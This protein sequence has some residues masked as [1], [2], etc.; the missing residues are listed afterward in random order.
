[1]SRPPA[2]GLR[3]SWLS[4]LQQTAETQL[5]ERKGRFWLTVWEV[6]VYDGQV[7]LGL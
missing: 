3:V 2:S 4:V 1:M 7:T 6:P 5:S